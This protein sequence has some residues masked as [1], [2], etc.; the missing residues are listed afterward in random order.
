M[1]K[2]TARQGVTLPCVLYYVVGTPVP[3]VRVCGVQK[4][5]GVYGISGAMVCKYVGLLDG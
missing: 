4:L 3:G 5:P 1:D 2:R